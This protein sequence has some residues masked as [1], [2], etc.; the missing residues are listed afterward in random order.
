M[1]RMKKQNLWFLAGRL[2]IGVILFWRCFYSV[3]TTDEA[4]YV[5]IFLEIYSSCYITIY[6]IVNC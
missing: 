4:F 2:G 1:E 6:N 3:N 5:Y